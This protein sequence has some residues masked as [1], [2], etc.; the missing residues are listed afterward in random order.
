MITRKMTEK[1][2]YAWKNDA[3]EDAANILSW[4]SERSRNGSEVRLSRMMNPAKAM[5]PRS[6]SI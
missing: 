1:F 6:S 3:K 2:A 5:V 4:K